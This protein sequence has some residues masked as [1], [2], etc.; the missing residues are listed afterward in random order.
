MTLHPR[1]IGI[2][3]VLALA[4]CRPG[5]AEYTD[6]E[7][8]KALTLDNASTQFEV[9]FV[10][11]SGR[12]A[13]A[14]AA[15]LRVLAARGSI[16][17]SDRI[18]IAAA[19]SPALAEAR[20]N[21]VAA[22]LLH[23]GIIPSRRTLASVPANHAVIQTGRYLVSLPP[24]P[25]W[26]SPAPLDFTNT[27]PSNMGCATAVNLGRMV[28]NPADIAEGRPVGMVDAIPAAAAVQRYQSDKVQLPSSATIGP[29]TAPTTAPPGS[30]ATGAGTAGSQP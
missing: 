24:C 9:R 26:S 18:T 16:A 27:H 22:E 6:L 30:G 29:I 13:A 3:L 8:S 25:N 28:W 5:A 2:G 1:L 19:G 15:R 21:T 11:G 14:D 17:P 10:P 20:F 23:Y 7:A 12:L 4:A